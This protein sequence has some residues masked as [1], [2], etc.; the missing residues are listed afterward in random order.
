MRMCRLGNGEGRGVEGK[1]KREQINGKG[2]RGEG[3][4]TICCDQNT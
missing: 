3:P 4:T 1:E 2:D